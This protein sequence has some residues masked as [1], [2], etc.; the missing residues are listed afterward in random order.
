[1]IVDCSPNSAIPAG[2]PSL[3]PRR[4]LI[5]GCS[6]AKTAHDGLVPAI[7][8]YDGPTFRVL[9]RYLR[10]RHDPE[11]QVYVLSAEFGLIPQH[12]PVPNY[13]RLMTEA[14]AQA[15]QMQIGSVLRQSQ[16]AHVDHDL[17]PVRLFVV[18]GKPYLS[19]LA[20]AA[21]PDAGIPHSCIGHGSQG[22]KL[23]ALYDWLYG[24]R[25]EIR[26]PQQP[27]D[28]DVP[29]RG[30]DVKLNYRD[31]LEFGRGELPAQ[32][33]NLVAWAVVVDDTRVAPKWLV[34]QATGA[35]VRSFTT[36]DALVFLARIGIQ[37][38]RV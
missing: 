20:I 36:K 7:E 2:A 38:E 8:R 24:D 18:A 37:V 32:A 6:K 25:P 33:T 19:A 31:V 11:L 16:S 26:H 1:M 21:A 3:P 28:S 17:D 12:H 14:R 30:V 13:D 4:L 34:S 10:E 5:L 22:K 9:R 15:L 29:F 35:P 23:A 27:R